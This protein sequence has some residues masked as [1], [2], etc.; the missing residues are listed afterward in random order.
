[1]ENIKVKMQVTT[2]AYESYCDGCGNG[3][4]K[5]THVTVAGSLYPMHYCCTECRQVLLDSLDILLKSIVE[6]EENII[7]SS[8]V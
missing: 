4:L 6:V 1:M 5:M 2:Q 3:A 7:I 8:G